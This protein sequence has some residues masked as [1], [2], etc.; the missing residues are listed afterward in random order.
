MSITSYIYI[1]RPLLP[2]C[3]HRVCIPV[4]SSQIHQV[5]FIK[6]IPLLI[7][8]GLDDATSPS[9][10]SPP[11]LEIQLL[12]RLRSELA[13]KQPI[14]LQFRFSQESE[15]GHRSIRTSLRTFCLLR[16]TVISCRR[17]AIAIWKRLF[18]SVVSF[19]F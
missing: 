9:F 18:V 11:L 16:S 8:S 5:H 14:F 6:S 10:P 4:F 17:R 1:V 19:P 13:G 2:I 15:F 12:Y 3:T 7:F